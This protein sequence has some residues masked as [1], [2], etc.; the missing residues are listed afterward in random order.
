[1]F[2]CLYSQAAERKQGGVRDWE[3][4]SKLNPQIAEAA[5]KLSSGQIS[6]VIEMP[7]ACYLIK[8]EDK[9]SA[10]TRPLSEVRDEIEATLSRD[11]KALL[12][13]RWIERMRKKTFVR[14]F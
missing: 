2:A 6:E 4:L 12:A 3:E 7:T 9:Q 13:K 5:G 1:M 10:H 11:Q 8:L 14:Y